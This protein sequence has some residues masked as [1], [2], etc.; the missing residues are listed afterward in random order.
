M[1]RIPFVLLDIGDSMIKDVVNHQIALLN[2]GS[3][4]VNY[5]LK[6]NFPFYIEQKDQRAGGRPLEDRRG[7]GR[8]GD[9]GRPGQL[10]TPTSR[11]VRPR[12]GP[13]T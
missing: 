11:S 10:R 6:S 3:S 12:A 5:A 7:R 2:L 13:T 9:D 1:T 4:D 8:H